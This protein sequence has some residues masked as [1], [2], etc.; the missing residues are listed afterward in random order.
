MYYAGYLE[1]DEQCRADNQDGNHVQRPPDK[2]ETILAS[3]GWAIVQGMLGC[4]AD[5]LR[6]PK[7]R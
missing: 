3:V 7:W 2:R 4:H 5:L 1:V 6:F